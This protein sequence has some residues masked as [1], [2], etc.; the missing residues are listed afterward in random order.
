MSDSG[1][2][3]VENHKSSM[4]SLIAAK[5]IM[6]NSVYATGVLFLSGMYSFLGVPMFGDEFESSPLS[7]V[8]RS[9]VILLVIDSLAVWRFRKLDTRWLPTG[10]YKYLKWFYQAL[11]VGV[12][13]I[14]NIGFL[15]VAW[16]WLRGLIL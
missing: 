5:I 15:A 6:L 7:M 4:Q 14:S 9:F 1:F 10:R 11:F 12:I 8:I 2:R 13:G 3:K 16:F